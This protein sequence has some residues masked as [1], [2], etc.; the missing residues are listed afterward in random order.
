MPCFMDS[1]TKLNYLTARKTALFLAN[2]S[3][4]YLTARNTALFLAK[5]SQNYL[6]ARNQA[7]F[8]AVQVHH[9]INSVAP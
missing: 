8:L 5:K 3:Q 4:N 9:S 6:T 7:L 2:K 1:L